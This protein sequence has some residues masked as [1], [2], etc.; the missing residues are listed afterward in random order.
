MAIVWPHGRIEHP[1]VELLPVEIDFRITHRGHIEVRTAAFP[2]DQRSC[3]T[4]RSSRRLAGRAT[5]RVII[6]APASRPPTTDQGSTCPARSTPTVAVLIPREPSKN[7]PCGSPA[8]CPRRPLAPWRRTPLVP[9]PRGRRAP[10]RAFPACRQPGPGRPTVANPAP[11]GLSA[12]HSHVSRGRSTSIPSG[13]TTYWQRRLAGR[14]LLSTPSAATGHSD[15]T[16]S[17]AVLPLWSAAIYR[18]LFRT[19]C[20]SHCGRINKAAINRRTPK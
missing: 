10:Q 5:R 13:S 20:S 9:C 17:S 2:P 3:E 11:P 16:R 19:M 15:A 8:A 14:S 1:V 18:R 4:K 7:T 6:T 12:A